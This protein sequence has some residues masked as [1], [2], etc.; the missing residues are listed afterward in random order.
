MTKVHAN[1]Y[2][3]EGGPLYWRIVC[4]TGTR[5][6]GRFFR[7]K[8]AQRMADELQT[9]FCDGRWVEKTARIDGEMK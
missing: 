8:S 1:R 9:A 3:V 7:W 5:S 4:G 6:L 2:R